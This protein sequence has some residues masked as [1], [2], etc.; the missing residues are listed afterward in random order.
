MATYTMEQY[1]QK[2]RDWMRKWPRA[3]MLTMRKEM[4]SVAAEAQEM[5]LSG[6]KMARG[7]GHPTLATL[8]APTGR[9]RGSVTVDPPHMSHGSIITGIGSNVPY[10]EVHEKGLVVRGVKMPERPWAMPSIEARRKFIIKAL[11]KAYMRAHRKA[12]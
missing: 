9:L 11:L 3:A 4:M 6:P 8:A 2:T 1:A 5:H 10:G 12:R 7:M